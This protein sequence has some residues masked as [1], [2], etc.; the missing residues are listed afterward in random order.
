M[1]YCSVSAA[2]VERLE[3]GSRLLFKHEDQDGDDAVFACPLLPSI[4]C[5]GD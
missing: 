3:K 2:S 5:T 1:K 4:Y